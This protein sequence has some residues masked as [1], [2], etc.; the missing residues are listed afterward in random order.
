MMRKTLRKT[1]FTTILASTASL[2]GCTILMGSIITPGQTV[3][4]IA[5]S[6]NQ[7]TYEYTHHYGSELPF[8]GK[9]AEQQCSRYGKEPELDSIVRKTIDR[10]TIDR[11]WVT[12]R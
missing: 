8:A 12:F 7:V 4:L 2:T 5:V 3:T 11:S 6:S 9:S 1:A 10:K